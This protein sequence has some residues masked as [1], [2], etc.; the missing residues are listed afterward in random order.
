[1]GTYVREF[2]TASGGTLVTPFTTDGL[3]PSTAPTITSVGTLREGATGVAF[4]GAN[5]AGAE[6]TLSSGDYSQAQSN[7]SSTANGGTF[8]VAMGDLPWSS[9]SHQVV[10]TVTTSEGTASLN[11]TLLPPDGFSVAEMGADVGGSTDEW[12]V[13]FGCLD[14]EPAAGA[15]V[16]YP[17]LSDAGAAVSMD[18]RG[19]LSLDYTG[20]ADYEALTQDQVTGL[21]SWSDGVRSEPVNKTITIEGVVEPVALTV[22]INDYTGTDTTPSLSGTID[23][24]TA[25]ISVNI[26]GT[27]YEGV[28][29]ADGTWGPLVPNPLSV[30]VHTATASATNSAGSSTATGTVTIEAVPTLSV[31]ISNTLTSNRTPILR[32]TVSNPLATVEATVDGQ[33]YAGDVDGYRWSAPVTSELDYGSYPVSVSAIL[34]DLSTNAAATLTVF[35]PADVVSGAGKRIG[36]KKLISRPVA[37]VIK[38]SIRA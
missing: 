11:V 1:M 10:L 23:D 31:S 33:Q 20:V 29:N 25:E 32:G 2:R 38:E 16:E 13:W 28:N 37:G 6:V 34:D 18:S 24:P 35:N 27:D 17:L 5:L 12:S 19:V 30:G 3:A 4:A 21:R 15:Q 8:D 26:G 14:G 22:T 36:F 7:V 9:A